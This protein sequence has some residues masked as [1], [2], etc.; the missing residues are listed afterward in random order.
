MLK[1]I[2]IFKLISDNFAIIKYERGIFKFNRESIL[3]ASQS[4]ST[5]K[6][7]FFR[8]SSNFK[9]REAEGCVRKA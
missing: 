4:A 9:E 7:S 8:H 5:F 6:M 2:C 1:V 3:F